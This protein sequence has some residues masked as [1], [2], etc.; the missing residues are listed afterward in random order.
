MKKTLS[1]MLALLLVFGVLFMAA[2]KKTES[3]D[4]QDEGD[5]QSQGGTDLSSL[6]GTYD[7][8]VWVSELD[9]V[10]E[11]TEQQIDAFEAANPGI[12]IN[13]TVEGVSEGESATQMIT[14]VEDG[15]DIFCFAQDQL[16]RLVMAGALNMLGEA[17][18]ATVT[19]LNDAGAVAA[20]S[21]GGSLYCFPLTS[22]NGYFMFYD[23][24]VISEDHID[25]LE[26]IIADCEAA[27]RMFSMELEGSAWYNAGFFFATGCESTW[28]TDL[29]GNFTNVTDTF[30]S[31]AGLVALKGMQIIL[32]SSA[33]NNSSAH[34]DFAAA[35]PSAVVISGTWG[36]S[37]AQEALGEN[38]AAADLPSF[39]VDGQTYH[40]GSFSGNKLLGVKPQTDATKA[41]VLQQLALYLTNEECQ[42]QRFESFGWGPSNLS[43]QQNETV[44]ND[45]ALSALAE[46]SAFAIPQGQ[47]HGSWWDIAKVYATSAKTAT[48]DDELWAALSQY[49]SA[50]QGL[51][52]MSEEVLNAF[53]VIGDIN[54]DG[55]TQDLPMVQQD[56][57][58][59]ITTEAYELVA[60]NE[61]KVR[62]GLSWDVAYG[63]DGNNYVVETAG[64]YFIKLTI[65]GEVGTVELV[66][67][68]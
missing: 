25:S 12:V 52:T 7:I 22:D 40:I 19:E 61:F 13:A 30:N 67:A 5:Q 42:L 23:K 20:A 38:F 14:S 24:S 59:W 33:Y 4:T 45:I 27:G 18:S 49:E 17:T 55:W 36:T 62:Q 53:T 32:K 9:G 28:T 8:T 43:A 60:G 34:A 6:A 68:D 10:K 29:D 66:P 15:A 39:T 57:G 16:A 37:I 41:A 64:T 51:F 26:D 21:V 56:D 11:L 46:Q 35:I 58:S 54:G 48:T 47:I 44:Q 50:I 1:I 65:E 63:T 3:G 2:C 31:D